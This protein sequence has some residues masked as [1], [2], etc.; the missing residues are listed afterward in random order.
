MKSII[1]SLVLGALM[2]CSQAAVF[3]AIDE[4]VGA[5]K[6]RIGKTRTVLNEIKRP[7][8]KMIITSQTKPENTAS[9]VPKGF[10]SVFVA[11]FENDKLIEEG[12]LLTLG[13]SREGLMRGAQAADDFVSE[14]LGAPKAQSPFATAVVLGM[15]AQGKSYDMHAGKSE[16]RVHFEGNKDVVSVS[17]NAMNKGAPAERQTIKSVQDNSN[18]EKVSNAAVTANNNLGF[19]ILANLV[20]TDTTHNLVLSPPGVLLSL[21][22]LA[23]AAS[24]ESGAAILSKLG[25]PTDAEQHKNLFKEFRSSLEVSAPNVVNDTRQELVIDPAYRVKP[26]FVELART[27]FG[28]EVKS[29]PGNKAILINTAQ[30]DAE[31]ADKFEVVSTLPGEFK[32]PNGSLVK[33]KIMHKYFRTPVGFYKE[34]LFKAVR[35]PYGRDDR[36]SMYLF[37]PSESSDLKT[38]CKELSADKFNTWIPKFKKKMG[39][40]EL[41]RFKNTLRLPVLEAVAATDV[42]ASVNDLKLTEVLDGSALPIERAEQFAVIEVNENGTKAS[43]VTE[44]VV[45]LSASQDVFDVRFTRPFVFVIRD[46]KQGTVLYLGTVVNPFDSALPLAEREKV[47]KEELAAAKK[48][49]DTRDPK[50]WNPRPELNYYFALERIARLYENEGKL[51]EAESYLKE[52]VD[53]TANSKSSHV[54]AVE[55]IADFYMRAKKFNEA[56]DSFKTAVDLRKANKLHIDDNG[57]EQSMEGYAFALQQA[58][59]DTAA[60][61]A[62]LEAHYLA[63]IKQHGDPHDPYTMELESQLALFYI[64][65]GA[66][67]KADELLKAVRQRYADGFYKSSEY[68]T[69]ED[70]YIEILEAYRGLLTKQRKMD[71]LPEL[72]K[73]IKALYAKSHHKLL[74]EAQ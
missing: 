2:V 32:T 11:V 57:L 14:T 66:L 49:F 18:T 30:L 43:A 45:P 53:A 19:K 55:R 24:A 51:A 36:F 38:F 33:A 59:R 3:A 9:D 27:A 50:G 62:E 25:L 41:V 54:D 35:L 69:K 73:Q 1:F 39:N 74:I 17:I 7:D 70:G 28:A 42:G 22:L 6:T 31:W 26:T 5:Y 68:S 13:T 40:L 64:R 8:G 44:V 60:I 15:A 20:S 65:S 72:E 48:Q 58:G 63:K 10:Q 29:A 67:Q 52:A 46:D 56:A 61:R 37:L 71:G 4:E 21:G 23:N 16:Y 34:D 47:W 12:L